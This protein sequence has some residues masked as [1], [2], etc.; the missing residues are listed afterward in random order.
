MERREA[1]IFDYLGKRRETIVDAQ[2]RPE[3][4]FFSLGFFAR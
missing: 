1:I 3:R 2:D 4:I